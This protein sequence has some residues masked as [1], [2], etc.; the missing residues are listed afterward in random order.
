MT[1]LDEI[2]YCWAVAE[3]SINENR[4]NTDEKLFLQCL[5]VRRN[6]VKFRANLNVYLKDTVLYF[7]IHIILQFDNFS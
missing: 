1:K 6:F 7:W 2:K 4:L 3:V 5:A